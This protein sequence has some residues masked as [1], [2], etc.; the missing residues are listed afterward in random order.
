MSPPL[1]FLLL[2]FCFLFLGYPVAL[3]LGGI[4]VLFALIG[5]FFGWFDI[6]LLNAVP[7]R[8][9]GVITNQTLL[10]VPPFVFMGLV[11]HRSGISD[12]L[13]RCLSHLLRRRRSGLLIAVTLTGGLL[14]ATT[15]IVGASVVTLGLLALPVLLRHNI[16]PSV[17]SGVIASSGTL[18][19][20]I[21]PSIVL[22]VLA[23]QISHAHIG[24][25]LS[26][27]SVDESVT[28]VDL[29]AGAILPGFLVIT[30]YIVWH[31]LS[32]LGSP[33]SEAIDSE[34][35]D[36]ETT[37]ND[38][39]PDT[40]TI[41]VSFLLPI[42]LVV[43]V[44]GGI[45]G[46]LATP[47]ESACIGAFG[48]LCLAYQKILSTEFLSSVLEESVHLVS[49][50]FLIVLSA[51]IFGLV[52]RGLGGDDLIHELF[53][54]LPGG[55]YGALLF[56]MLLI[57]FL[58]FFLEFLEITYLVLPLVTPV[59]LSLPMSDGSLMNPVWLGILFAL[60]L[61]TSFLT[62]PLGVSLFYLRGVAP[63]SVTTGA[64][65]RGVIPYILIQILVLFIV[66]LF[67]FL[68]TFLPH[69]FFGITY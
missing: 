21:P 49:M 23:D 20:L 50:I 53:D 37:D 54:F 28:I 58:G 29:F 19:Q 14:A 25:R 7:S 63:E 30:L 52:F 64:M 38:S 60:T 26:G 55:T 24:V 18:G 8:L 44:L 61:Q 27:G 34:T 42:F 5:H 66:L 4:S 48:A 33:T 12:S 3:T 40:R 57:F 32:G 2:T 13:F 47:V 16:S 56:V 6:F 46:G 45:L 43:L 36:S 15:G 31:L 17:A 39:P 51:S 68:A 62:P 67:P 41:L 59:L 9:F 69:L 11:L 65:Y 1:L 22:I 35:T 10:A